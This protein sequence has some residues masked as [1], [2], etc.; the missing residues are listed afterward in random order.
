MKRVAFIGSL[1]R[2]PS[3]TATSDSDQAQSPETPT[4]GTF[5][6]LDQELNAQLS[7]PVKGPTSEYGYSYT[8]RAFITQETFWFYSCVLLTCVTTVAVRLKDIKNV[9]LIRDTS[10]TDSVNKN[11][12]ANNIALAIDIDENNGEAQGPLVLTTL[13]DDV[14]VVAERLR[15]A[16]QSAKSQEPWPLQVMY[17]VIRNMSAAMSKNSTVTTIIKK[18]EQQRHHPIRMRST[19]DLH[20]AAAA[21]SATMSP[22]SSAT[23]TTTTTATG[24]F[25]QPEPALSP[26]PDSKDKKK[27]RKPRKSSGS[28]K[29][30]PKSGALAAAMMAATVAGGSGFFDASKLVRME[31]A[32]QK[33]SSKQRPPQVV[34]ES[35]SSIS[36]DQEKP[37]VPVQQ[38]AID[39]SSS[40][41]S[42]AEEGIISGIFR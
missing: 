23:T 7:G 32:M 20:A 36:L 35:S 21:T 25:Y 42:G 11:G 28:N 41:V 27:Q 26:I 4:S 22:S 18:S 13:L 34:P 29:P 17:D 30:V 38:S 10:I 37:P 33:N 9:R 2:K 5:E 14:E 3:P 16:I 19:P 24:E 31:E 6:S 8:G 1:K 15:I 39:A 40:S 12:K